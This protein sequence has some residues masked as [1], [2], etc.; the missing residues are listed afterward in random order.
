MKKHEFEQLEKLI[1]KLNLEV[2]GKAICILNGH[3]NDGY[4]I[5]VFGDD[6]NPIKQGN[7]ATIEGTVKNLSYKNMK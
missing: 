4:H 7:G 1:G 5:R 2:G 3:I 6:G